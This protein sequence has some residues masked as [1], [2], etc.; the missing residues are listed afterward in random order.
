MSLVLPDGK[1]LLFF[2]SALANAV[3]APKIYREPIFDVQLRQIFAAID[4]YHTKYGPQTGKTQ[5]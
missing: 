1:I 2:F 3:D 5:W 4:Y